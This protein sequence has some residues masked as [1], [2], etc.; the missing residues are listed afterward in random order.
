MA[1]ALRAAIITGGGVARGGATNVQRGMLQLRLNQMCTT[2]ALRPAI[3][4]GGG[5]ARGG[6]TN[7]QRGM[8]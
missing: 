5:V 1:K 3:I 8:L 4:T 2:G 7:V 6:A